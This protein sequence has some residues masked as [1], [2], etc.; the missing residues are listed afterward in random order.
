[1]KLSIK[2][3][4]GANEVGGNKILVSSRETSIM[5]DF[6][7][8]YSCRRKFFSDPFITPKNIE[9]LIKLG[10]IPEIPE[11]YYEKFEKNVDAIFLSHVHRDHTGHIGVV[12]NDVKI[13]TGEATFIMMKTLS[14]IYRKNIETNIEGKSISYFHTGDSIKV[15]DF[16]VIPVHVDH[17]TP[18]AY[19]FLVKTPYGN[20]AYTGDFRMHGPKSKMT[21]DFIEKV[22]SEGVDVLITEHT[23]MLDGVVSSEEEVKNKIKEIV[24]AC[25]GLVVSDFAL[26][27][28]DRYNSFYD[29]AK[30]SGRKLV[31][32]PKRAAILSALKKDSR[33]EIRTENTFV[34]KKEKA[35]FFDWEEEILKE[36]NSIEPKDVSEK[37]N[38]YVALIPQTD[39]QLVFDISPKPGSIFIFS[40]SEPFNEE[41]E[42]DYDRLINWLDAMGVPMYTAHVSGHVMPIHLKNVIQEL[43]PKVVIPVHGENPELLKK[44]L[45]DLET[46]VRIPEKEEEITIFSN[47]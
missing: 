40:S 29:S 14:E 31:V 44:Y 45:R 11:L 38:E 10:I 30:E 25:K 9:I 26:T 24:N 18:G 5:L 4:G 19:G 37:Q 1:M 35:K 12:R 33:I 17:S 20:I 47:I 39:I 13:Y 6:G 27:D 15:N 43:K 21:L 3:L 42:I 32:T 22:K 16:E 23:N 41:M 36:W 7:M 8:S 28:I 46:E 34:I 2:V